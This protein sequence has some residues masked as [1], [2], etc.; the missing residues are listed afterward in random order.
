MDLAK[1]SDLQLK[2]L[3]ETTEKYKEEN[4]KEKEELKYEL[5]GALKTAE[6]KQEALEEISTD[7]DTSRGEQEKISNDLKSQLA[8]VKTELELALI[9]KE[10]IDSRVK[11]L[12]EEIIYYKADAKAATDNYEREL[13]LHATARDSFRKLRLES[14][15]NAIL[16]EKGEIFFENTK[17][18]VEIERC[19]W[20]DKKE[21]PESFLI[22]AEKR[23]NEYKD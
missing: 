20:Q 7:L 16:R 14:K 23:L 15:N 1:V 19:D 22:L 4:D 18:N 12:N 3:M 8:I 5:S 11:T 21:K 2:E 17:S 9:N 10:T 6:I 13:S